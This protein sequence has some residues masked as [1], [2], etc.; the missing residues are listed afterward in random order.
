MICR[1]LGDFSMH[2][3][4]RD[5][6]Q[7][8]TA[9]EFVTADEQSVQTG[10]WPTEHSD[11]Y[12][13][14]PNQFQIG[15]ADHRVDA[16][17]STTPGWETRLAA[18]FAH[19]DDHGSLRTRSSDWLREIIDR[20]LIL[21]T[22]VSPRS[23]LIAGASIAIFGLGW[24][25]G[26]A[27]GS[28][29][30][31]SATPLTQRIDAAVQ[32]VRD[33]GVI[34]N[35]AAPSPTVA[36][37]NAKLSASAANPREKSPDTDQTQALLEGTIPR[38]ARK[39][40]PKSGPHLARIDSD[41]SPRHSPAPETK[42]TTIPGWSVRSVNGDRA[43]LVSPDRVWTVKRGDTVPGVGRINTIVRWGDNW[44]VVTGSGLIS[45]E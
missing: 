42:P 28:G 45:T 38:N 30:N 4:R 27:F 3:E 13:A 39:G 24:A 22:S 40:A 18:E 29:P 8:L 26:S 15:L 32:D 23:W 33:S 19:F 20:F 10:S 2:A 35:G 11:N 9:R 1:S 5:H 36:E 43:V 21:I 34:K 14:E 25:A 37:S 12:E 41:P 17:G 16:T 44:I 31:L 6:L 7:H